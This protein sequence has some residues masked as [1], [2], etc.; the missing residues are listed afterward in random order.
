M[1]TKTQKIAIIDLSATKT[2]PTVRRRELCIARLI[3]QQRLLADAKVTQRWSGKGTERKS[4]ERRTVVRPWWTGTK[5][6]VA[7]RLRF[8]SGKRGFM[9]GNMTELHGAIDSIIEEIKTGEL[10]QLITPVKKLKTAKKPDVSKAKP[11]S[12]P[13]SAP[14]GGTLSGMLRKKTA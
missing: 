13:V 6:G 8:V 9:V 3:D 10:D 5:D 11:L 2:D 12:T 1:T 7:L 4:T 14:K